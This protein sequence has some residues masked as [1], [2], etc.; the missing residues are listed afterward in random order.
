MTTKIY[1]HRGAREAAPEN[2]IP[3]FE[4]ALEM[5]A[6]GVELDVQ[7]SSDGKLMVIHDFHLGDLTDGTGLTREQSAAELMKLDAGSHFSAE[8]ANTRIPTLD[9][10]MDLLQ[11]RCVVNVEIKSEDPEGGAEVEPLAEMITRRGLLDQVIVS[12]FNPMSLIKM[13]HVM[14]DVRIG[15]L[16]YKPLPPHLAAAWTSSII[17]PQALHPH[18]SLVDEALMEWARELE[19]AVNVWTVNEVDEARRLV[20]LGVDVVMTD[21]PDVMLEALG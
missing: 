18:F 4:K 2:T 11:D 12:S 8:Y 17:G 6:A 20:E 3:A 10:V 1:A 19:C 13:R 7:C 5:G 14:P 9:A 21:V 16:F 15:L